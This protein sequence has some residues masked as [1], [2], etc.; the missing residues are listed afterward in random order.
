MPQLLGTL[1]RGALAGLLGGLL[2]GLFGFLLAE[3][4]IDQAV[5]LEAARTHTPASGEVFSRST[6]H[7]GL[8]AASTATGVALGALLG[9][10]YAVLHRAD[11]L[12]DPWRRSLTLGAAAFFGL[13]LV[14]FVRYPANPPGVG[15]PDTLGSRTAA[16]L[17][18]VVVGVVGA[19]V[20][21]QTADLLRRRG[22][23]ASHRQLA[24]T[25]VLIGA[26]AIPFAIPADQD[27][28][29][30]PAGLLWTFRLLAVATAV[31]LWGGLTACFGLLG[32]RAA[33]HDSA[34]PPTSHPAANLVKSPAP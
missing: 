6:Q 25:A 11:P 20:A 5:R 17:I 18:A 28:L 30:V 22:T 3:P 1:R 15:D 27:P 34:A 8:I 23:R 13:Y 29:A 33:A 26:L 12:A 14:P 7:V 21:G 24:V 4:L 31:V 10:L 32:E 19:I 16:Y 2:A 9:V